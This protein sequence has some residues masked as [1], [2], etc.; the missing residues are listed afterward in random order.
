MRECLSE[1]F[2]ERSKLIQALINDKIPEAA[3]DQVVWLW[4][5]Y[6]FELRVTKGRLSKLGDYRYDPANKCH[7]ISVNGT[8]NKYSFLITLVHEIAHQ[9]VRIH[10][11][12][13]MPH[14]REWKLMFKDLMLPFLRPEIFP[15]DVLRRLSKHMIN[16]KASSSADHVLT[17]L[18]SAY[19]STA[20][21]G[22]MLKD[23]TTGADFR[24]RGR[25]YR[26]LKHRRTRSI[27]EDRRTMKRYL[28]PMICRVRPIM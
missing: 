11:S 16:P 18:L 17:E 3:V 10:H 1:C 28:I 21:V 15:E 12:R 9:H 14:G 26:L 24:F 7:L 20:N 4:E 22:P 13:V 27:C 19:D 25:N 23:L 6:P 5:Q 2:S 8:L